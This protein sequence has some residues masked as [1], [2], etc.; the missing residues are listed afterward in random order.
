M[1]LLKKIKKKL[2]EK[3]IGKPKLFD[4]FENYKSAIISSN[5]YDD[6]KL[7]KVIVEK[8]KNFKQNQNKFQE[9]NLGDFRNIFAL[10]NFKNNSNLTVLDFG[11]GAG[12]HYFFAKKFLDKDI[13]IN[14]D[15]IETSSLVLKVKNE[16]FENDELK[17]FNSLINQEV[18]EKKYDLVYANSSLPYTNDP[19]DFLKKLLKINFKYLYI[20]RTPLNENSNNQI[21]GLQISKLS[22][23]GPGPMPQNLK[24]EDAEISYPF[25]VLG[26][27]VVEH[28]I[29][30][31]GN[32]LFSFREET[33]AYKTVVGNFS[34]FGYFIKKS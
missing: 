17:F 30:K 5:S 20:T 26:K 24:F 29:Q 16:G 28:E 22:S 13:K 25:T 32:I 7:I 19:L 6:Q 11:G 10:L 8:T 3:L 21:I 15:V 1:N 4:T 33:D 2:I 9:F 14:W 23:N 12:A 18:I 31:Y 34:N 27:E